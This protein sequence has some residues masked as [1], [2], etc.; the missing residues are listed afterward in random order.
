M[1]QYKIDFD[2]MPWHAPAA[3]VR[4]KAYNQ[5]GRKLRLAEFGKE[6]VEHGWCDKGHIGYILEGRLEI[7]FS[8]NTVLFG[9]GEGIFIPAGDQHK[10]KGRAITETVKLILVED[11]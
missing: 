2:A 9:P 1:E 8:G 10:H 4:F 7:D 3:G 6:F 5:A 11:M